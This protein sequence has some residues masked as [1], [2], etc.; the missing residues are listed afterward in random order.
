MVEY[1]YGGG[2]RLTLLDAQNPKNKL[3]S[4]PAPYGGEL[5]ESVWMG[6]IIYALAI[7]E[8]GLGLFSINLSE[9][10]RLHGGADV[11]S[12][13]KIVIDEQHGRISYLGCSD[14]LLHFEADWDGVNNIYSFDPVKGELGR[15]TNARFAAHSP[16]VSQGK[17]YYTNLEV[18]GEYPVYTTVEKITKENDLYFD[19]GKIKNRYE[20]PVANMLQQQAKAFFNDNHPLPDSTLPFTRYESKPYSKAAHLFRPHSWAPVYYNVDK[21]MQMNF[22]NLYDAAALGATVYSQ[23]TLGTAVGML[24]YSYR[25]GFHA[26]HASFEYRGWYPVFKIEAHYNSESRMQY[27]VIDAGTILV[28]MKDTGE[29]LFEMVARSYLPLYFNSRG[30]QRGFIPQILWKYDNNKFYSYDKG[31]YM[32][33]HQLNYAVQYY[34]NRPI[35][36][37]AIFPRWGFNVAVSGSISPGGAENFGSVAAVNSYIYLPGFDSKQ[38]LKI[39]LAYQKQFNENKYYYLEN[40]VSMPRGC[41]AYYCDNFYKVS[42]DYA[43]PVNFNGLDLGFVG[44]FK[45]LQV[46]PFGEY[47]RLNGGGGKLG[48]YSFGTD[49][50]IDGFLFKIGVPLSLGVRYAHTNDPG[51][52]NHFSL[53]FSTSMF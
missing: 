48:L 18:S 52:E 6:N 2:S 39:G 53:L 28:D 51:N 37:A 30:W 41:D 8:R 16:K 15:M 44:Y 19:N 42:A 31:K 7:T 40:L 13:W 23:N 1:H 36:T 12:L 38:G 32:P 11:S 25:K 22:D 3:F 46:I 35:A 5:T 27:K 45:R 43:I 21:I 26:G 20:Y 29:P 34:Q 9:A 17:L 47:A 4:I 33:R 50:L 10:T 24:G 49:L 14:N